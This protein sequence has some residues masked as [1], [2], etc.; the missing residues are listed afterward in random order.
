ME[1]MHKATL[2][3]KLHPGGGTDYVLY[4]Q[5]RTGSRHGRLDPGPDRLCGKRST[6]FRYDLWDFLHVRMASGDPACDRDPQL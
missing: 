1:K 5:R 3:E 4:R 6:E 2:A